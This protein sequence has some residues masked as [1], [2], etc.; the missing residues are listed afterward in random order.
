[1]GSLEILRTARPRGRHANDLTRPLLKNP[2]LQCLS[3]A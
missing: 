1:M 2:V 3:V